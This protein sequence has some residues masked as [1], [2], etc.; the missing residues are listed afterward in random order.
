MSVRPLRR[1]WPL[2]VCALFALTPA[3]PLAAQ[4]GE[5]ATLPGDEA[6]ALAKEG[7]AFYEAGRWAE[8]LERFRQADQR[9]PSP[10]FKLYVA[11]TQRNLQSLLASRELYRQIVAEHLP[12]DAPPSFPQAQADARAEL[13][14]LELTIPSIVVRAKGLSASAKLQI[15]GKP[16]SFG[17]AVELDPG[18]VV[19]LATDG[20]VS[21][22]STITLQLSEKNREVELS[23]PAQGDPKSPKAP[24]SPDS[25]PGLLVPGAI[26]A[27][28]GG[29][30]LVAGAITGAFA[31]DIDAHI[32][33]ECGDSPSCDYEDLQSDQDS[34]LM[35]ANASTSTLV[36][37]GVLAAV[38]VV[39]IAVD[40]TSAKPAKPESG[41]ATLLV[42]PSSAALRVAF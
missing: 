35:L 41:R 33:D 15:A 28:I 12:A 17:V 22:E 30:S 29:A 27:A 40:L 32:V 38:G 21:A 13:N 1:C 36:I 25:G 14:A 3:G 34:E 10:V 9:F 6:V 8:A 16:A 2:V 7:L 31:L 42:A 4:P 18:P 26:L 24:E 11:R 19:I 5:P 37:G 20:A 23:P 39:L